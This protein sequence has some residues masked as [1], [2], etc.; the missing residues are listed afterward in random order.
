MTTSR[1]TPLWFGAVLGLAFALA[2]LL[3]WVLSDRYGPGQPDEA[4]VPP[5]VTRDAAPV[6]SDPGA[7]AGGA[8]KVEFL[9]INVG[10]TRGHCE[11]TDRVIEPG[12]LLRVDFGISALEGEVAQI[13]GGTEPAGQDQ[14]V[15]FVGRHVRRVDDHIGG[16]DH[17]VHVIRCG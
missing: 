10:P 15:Q 4:R 6:R 5:V 11:P 1:V 12:A 13:L 14:R 2:I 17:D 7:D 16:G 8:Q 9:I 3:V